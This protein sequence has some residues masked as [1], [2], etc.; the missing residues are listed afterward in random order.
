[1]EHVT[2]NKTLSP[3]KVVSLVQFFI[4]QDTAMSQIDRLIVFFADNIF[5]FKI[6]LNCS[7]LNGYKTKNKLYSSRAGIRNQLN[8]SS[9]LF[10]GI[11][12]GSS[13]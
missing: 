11:S 9:L 5:S 2:G 10:L 7:R 1:M 4:L 6:K 8:L 3:I 13:L 12:K